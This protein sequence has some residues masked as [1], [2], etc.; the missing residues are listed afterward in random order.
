M[1]QRLTV[2]IVSDPHYPGPAEKARGQDY[3]IQHIPKVW[4]RRALQM[5]RHHVWMRDPFH[6]DRLLHQFLREVRAE[7][8]VA[9]GDYSCDSAFIGVA[10][11][12]AFASAAECIGLLRK[13]FPEASLVIGDH[14][15]G[16]LSF[17][18]GAGGMRVRSLQRCESELGLS[19]GWTT[20]FGCYVLV[21]ITSSLVGFPAFAPDALPEERPAWEGRRAQHMDWIRGVFERLDPKQKVILFCHDPTALPYL[22]QEDAVRQR[23]NQ[24]EHTVIGHL[25]SELILWKSRVLSGIPVLRRFGHT[26]QRLT[27]ALRQARDWR[28]FH[29]RLCPALAGIQL[30]KDGGYLTLTLDLSS[31]EPARFSRMRLAR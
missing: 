8:L 5:Y 22:W 9:N 3:E 28:W 21:G 31:R 18:G 1:T 7:I 12:A 30:L 25:H 10:D 14:E 24:I 20:V 23:A 15:L 2:A 4:Q 17:L 16:K 6:K 27:T 29:V 26:T 11:D 13:R 19:P